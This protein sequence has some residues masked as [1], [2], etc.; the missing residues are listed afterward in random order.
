LYQSL[1]HHGHRGSTASRSKWQIRTLEMHHRAEYGI[2]AT[3]G[4]KEKE[5]PNPPEMAG[6][7]GSP[8]SIARPMIPY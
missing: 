1:R 5:D 4:Y 8:T 6:C 7:N 2:A 3:L